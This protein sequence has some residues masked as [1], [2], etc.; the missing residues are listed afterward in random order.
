M[1]PQWRGPHAFTLHAINRRCKF[2]HTTF[3]APLLQDCSIMTSK[4]F[5]DIAPCAFLRHVTSLF[6]ACR[7][8]HSHSHLRKK[9]I[10]RLKHG[11]LSVCL[12]LL[13]RHVEN[14]ISNPLRIRFVNRLSIDLGYDRKKAGILRRS[15][16][17]CHRQPQHGACH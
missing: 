14:A 8:P 12:R 3:Y 10:L 13:P 15:V 7:M 9:C 17:T 5:S 1:E 2:F 4:R 11:P 6:F 16:P